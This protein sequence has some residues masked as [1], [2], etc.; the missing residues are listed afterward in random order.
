MFY[1][2][3]LTA[4]IFQSPNPTHH[5]TKS[6]PETLLSLGGSE[7]HKKLSES[8]NDLT[9]DGGCPR[10]VWETP[11]GTPPPGTPPPPYPSPR[12]IRREFGSTD[13]GDNIFDEVVNFYFCTYV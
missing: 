13:E 8:L 1:I 10:E 6:S 11:P 4:E 7:R 12:A 9:G 3:I 5:R 2:G